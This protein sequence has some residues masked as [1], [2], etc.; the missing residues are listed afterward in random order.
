MSE[1]L[2]GEIQMFADEFNPAGW[3]ACD[4]RLLDISHYTALFEAIGTTYGGDGRTT[5]ALPDLRGNGTDT[6]F[7]IQA[8]EPEVLLR[9]CRD[10]L[11]AGQFDEIASLPVPIPHPADTV[12][13]VD[14]SYLS[15]EAQQVASLPVPIPEPFALGGEI[16]QGGDNNWLALSTTEGST[17][18]IETHLGSLPDTML[19]VYDQHGQQVAFND[20]GGAGLASRIEWA[21]PASGV[22]F[23]EVSAYAGWQSGSYE[24][25]IDVLSPPIP[26]PT[27]AAID[28][29]GDADLF[30]FEAVSGQHFVI[31]T[32]L[33]SGTLTD[34]VLTL[35]DADGN[36][37]AWNDDFGRS[38]A[39]RIDWTAPADGTYYFSV[40]AYSTV[41]T[42]SYAVTLGTG[43]DQV[44]S[45]PVPLL[46]P[47]E[48]EALDQAFEDQALL[49]VPHWW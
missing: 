46:Y 1:P 32:G 12:T 29:G 17:Y 25:D 9:N 18:V 28:I 38:L 14:E 4:G 11:F 27:Q 19:T 47:V 5:F 42:G 41:Q 16:R 13:W 37:L 40:S 10:E 26:E 22:Y 35:Y 15:G 43:G 23:V 33:S 31:Q 30:A 2:L 36:Q 48:S 24:L 20:D 3:V 34:S 45:L 8:E 39:S 21:A 49:G 44:S 7:M 6:V